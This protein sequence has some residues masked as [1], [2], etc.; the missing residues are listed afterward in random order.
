MKVLPFSIL[1]KFAFVELK[2]AYLARVQV[3]FG[4]PRVQNPEVEL[5]HQKHVDGQSEQALSMGQVVLETS[6]QNGSSFEK[7]RPRPRRP[8][9]LVKVSEVNVALL[10]KENPF[11][12]STNPLLLGC[13]RIK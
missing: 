10:Q 12:Y 6:P 4:R 11:D 3:D 13:P 2:I 7:K 8:K 9:L 1:F 5:E